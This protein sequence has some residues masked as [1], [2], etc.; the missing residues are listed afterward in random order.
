MEKN[1]KRMLF[2]KKCFCSFI[3]IF[4]YFSS[5]CQVIIIT[6]DT[7]IQIEKDSMIKKKSDSL[8]LN[9]HAYQKDSSK[10]TQQIEKSFEG[11][12]TFQ[13]QLKNPN[14]LLITDEEFYRDIPNGGKSIAYLYIKGNRYKWIYE[15]QIEVYHQ[16]GN[17][18]CIKHLKK[19]KDTFYCLPTH[20]EE[21]K[22]NHFEKMIQKSQVLGQ[23]CHVFAFKNLFEKR[24]FHFN[25]I[26]Q[27]TNGSLWANHHKDF[28]GS[29][30]FKSNSFPLKIE[31]S[32]MMHQYSL[33]CIKID[34]KTLNDKDFQ[35]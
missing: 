25:P 16:N 30:L 35:F 23:T 21:D 13:K 8:P 20:L 18:V 2:L 29:F 4:F 3:F 1:I 9:T 34:K 24:I 12:L 26:S 32:G 19:D 5:F 14:K 6:E 17:K 28:F 31:V 27:K 10:T 33:T 22:P 15:D 7:E 11:V